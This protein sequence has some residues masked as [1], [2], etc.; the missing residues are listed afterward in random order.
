MKEWD[1]ML[2][3]IKKAQMHRDES[4]QRL[5]MPIGLDAQGK[6]KVMALGLSRD[7]H[8]VIVGSDR[9]RV[10]NIVN[11]LGDSLYAQYGQE[12]TA[13]IYDVSDDNTDVTRNSFAGTNIVHTYISTDN[14]FVFMMDDIQR[15][16]QE[17][18]R[19]LSLVS[20]KNCFTWNKKLGKLI[21]NRMTKEEEYCFQPAGSAPI[22]SEE[23]KMKQRVYFIVGGLDYLY[24]LPSWH[25]SQ[26]ERSLTAIVRL[27]RVTGIHIVL[28]GSS[29]GKLKKDLVD[30]ITSRVVLRSDDRT[31]RDI[32][33]VTNFD[34]IDDERARVQSVEDGGMWTMVILPK[35]IK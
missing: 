32:L 31:C 34:E 1:D 26:V 12:I 20:C 25:L 7:V 8:G 29:V 5:M 15:E 2:S 19:V 24:T 3:E 11:S 22:W 16:V 27:A 9:R 4:D 6:L 23:H 13:H 28:T 33:G 10:E 35:Y 21:G 17:R 14:E 30:C 18:Y